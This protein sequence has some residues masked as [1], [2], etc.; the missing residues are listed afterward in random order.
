MKIKITY[1]NEETKQMF[2]QIG[3]HPLTKIMNRMEQERID[4][5]NALHIERMIMQNKEEIELL[6]KENCLKYTDVVYR[7]GFIHGLI[8]DRE[9]IKAI[10]HTRAK[11]LMNKINGFHYIHKGKFRCRK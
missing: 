6:E 3:N 5:D 9:E 4:F 2:E 11:E 7:V 1:S 8:N 10:S